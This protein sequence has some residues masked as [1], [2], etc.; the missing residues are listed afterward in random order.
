MRTPVLKYLFNKGSGLKACKFIKMGLQHR[1][2]PVSVAK[3][4]KVALFI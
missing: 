4:L 2:F 3:F 1:C